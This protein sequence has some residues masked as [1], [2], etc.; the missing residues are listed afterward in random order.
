MRAYR[1]DCTEKSEFSFE[2]TTLNTAMRAA[3]RGL[4]SL[5]GCFGAFSQHVTLSVPFSRTC[6]RT[7]CTPT[8]LDPTLPWRPRS[9]SKARMEIPSVSPSRMVMYQ[10]RTVN[11]RWSKRTFWTARWPRTRRTQALPSSLPPQLRQLWVFAWSD[12]RGPDY[13]KESL[14]ST[15]WSWEI[16][17]NSFPTWITLSI[18]KIDEEIAKGLH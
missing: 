1:D 5:C 6:F 17:D 18:K 14:F 11:S 12:K 15:L 3:C 10:S 2:V 16:W 8:R 9:G 7:T 4:S 13:I